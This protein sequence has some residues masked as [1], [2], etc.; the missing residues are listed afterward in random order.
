MMMMLQQSEQPFSADAGEETICDKALRLPV[1]L[2][3]FVICLM[4]HKI[5]VSITS[6]VGR[7]RGS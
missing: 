1:R 5:D 4:T 3:T 7:E 6:G 2:M